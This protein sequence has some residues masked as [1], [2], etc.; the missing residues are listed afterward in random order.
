MISD[1]TTEAL[2]HGL[3]G[4]HARQRAIAANLA[5]IET[6][7]YKAQNV[8]FEDQLAAAIQQQR[9]GGSSDNGPTLSTSPTHGFRDTPARGDGNTVDIETET[10]EMTKSSLHYR[11]LS[12]VLRK[13]LQMVRLAI[14]GGGGQ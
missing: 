11:Y 1:L 4:V 10:M 5:N 9:T 13:K 7:G 6:P 14:N 8:Q 2:Q 3:D 12:R